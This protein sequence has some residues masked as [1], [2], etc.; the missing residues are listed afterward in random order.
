MPRGN[1]ISREVGVGHFGP[2]FADAACDQVRVSVQLLPLLEGDDLA[3]V[4]VREGAQIEL[5]A[6]REGRDDVAD[7]VA[8][9]RAHLR[10]QRQRGSEG[11]EKE[12][13]VGLRLVTRDLGHT[14]Q[15]FFVGSAVDLSAQGQEQLETLAGRDQRGV[16][17]GVRGACE[18]VGEANR[19]AHSGGKDAQREIEGAGDALQ[20]RAEK[21]GSRGIM[22]ESS[23]CELL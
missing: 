6:R 9:R 16:R 20:K 8:V 18:E 22:H 5:H 21:E 17:D 10:E 12:L 3:G 14:G 7:G 1:I 19:I 23:R 13:F 11:L 15:G 2:E 4:L